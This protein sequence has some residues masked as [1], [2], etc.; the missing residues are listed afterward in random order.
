[1]SDAREHARQ[2]A[3]EMKTCSHFTGIQNDACKADVNYRKLIGGPDFGWAKYLPCL[4]DP[5]AVACEKRTF[6]APEEAEAIV[7]H[8]DEAYEAALLYLAGKG[9]L[10]PGMTVIACR[11]EDMEPGENGDAAIEG[12]APSTPT[13]P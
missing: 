11:Q 10:P 5:K 9:A 12:G 1:M 7:T 13:K 6:P 2:V 3:R 4:S 8:M